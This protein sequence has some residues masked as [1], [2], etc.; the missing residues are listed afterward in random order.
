MKENANT[1]QK[2]ARIRDVAQAAGV[3]TATVSRALSNPKLL[4]E[5]TRSAVFDAIQATGYSLNH[6]ARNLRKQRAG[7]VVVLVPNLGNPFF[8]KI[9]SGIN[10]GFEDTDYSVLI[11]DT[12]RLPS[13]QKRMANYFMQ[14]RIDGMVALD[15]R[16]SSENL[17]VSA[18]D[19][20]V[21]A[22]EWVPDTV[23]PSVRSDNVKG[24]QL[25]IQHLFDLGHRQIAHIT[26]PAGNVLTRARRDSIAPERKR[27]DLPIR[28]GW[29]IRG[30]FSLQAGFDSAAKI[31]A[32]KERPS[33]VFCA[34]DEVALGLI[35][36]LHSF[37]I[38]VPTDISVVGF[39]DIE[40][41]EFC[42]PALTTIRQ[43][44]RAL[45]RRAANLLLERL[46]PNALPSQGQVE[47]LD[48]E[49]I[50]RDSTAPITQ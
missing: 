41:S 38:R 7:A 47:T 4:S 45:G 28:E 37:G 9:L 34:S 46:S 13:S 1:N 21:F 11:S 25:A 29:I 49:L 24:A 27:L 39:D 30:D 12:A 32:M 6:A 18:V 10:E 3:S 16:L 35:S 31:H 2:A 8:S 19:K 5:S 44:R 17:Q 36:G 42:L 40:L 48:V 14:A 15:G 33:A 22:C 20:I 23:F 43:D 50:V 26:G